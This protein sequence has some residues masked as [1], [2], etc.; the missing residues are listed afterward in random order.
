MKSD[1]LLSELMLLQGHGR[2]STREI[3]S[4]SVRQALSRLLRNSA[5]RSTIFGA[6][7]ATSDGATVSIAAPSS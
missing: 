3:R 2:L 1:R 7:A 6:G 5:L 4:S